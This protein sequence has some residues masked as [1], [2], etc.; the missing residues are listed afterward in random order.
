MVNQTSGP[1]IC[2]LSQFLQWV[3]LR[4][5]I[6]EDED[7]VYVVDYDYKLSKTNSSKLKDLRCFFTTKRLIKQAIKS[8]FF[9]IT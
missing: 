3:K 9:S 4:T 7:K 6:P 5:E 1:L 2:S 8:I